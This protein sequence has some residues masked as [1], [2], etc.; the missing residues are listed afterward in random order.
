MPKVAA[1]D[2]T[3]EKRIPGWTE[4]KKEK[5]SVGAEELIAIRKGIDWNN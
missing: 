2:L 5:L 1:S 4:G 3:K